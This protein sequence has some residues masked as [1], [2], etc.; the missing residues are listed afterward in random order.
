[1]ASTEYPRPAHKT[2]SIY[3]VLAGSLIG[4]LPMIFH[5]NYLLE[6]FYFNNEWD[7][8]HDMELQGFFNWVFAFR[9]ELFFPVSKFL[10]AGL[11]FAGNGDYHVLIFAVFL[12]HMLILFLLGYLM[13]LWGFGLL[14]T[15]F[16]QCVLGANY[17]HIEI[18]TWTS[19]WIGLIALTSL[20]VIIIPFANAYL[21]DKKLS[22][23]FCVLIFI[24][25]ALGALSFGRGVLNGFVLLGTCLL[26]FVL[27]DSSRKHTWLPA[28]YAVIPC[29]LVAF[30]IAAWS[31][32]RTAN[33]ADSGSQVDAIISWF[34]YSISLN[35]WYQQIRGLQISVGLSVM[36]FALN[37]AVIVVGILL[38]NPKQ[39]PF[40]YLLI[41][42][43]L[44]DAALLALGRNHLPIETVPSWR[45]QYFSILVFAPFVG[46]IL[47][48]IVQFIPLQPVRIIISVVALLLV[49]KWVFDPWA[50]FLPSWS[51]SRGTQTKLL[52][53]SDELD[54]KAH[55]IY[56][57]P[58]ITNDRALELQEKYNL[59]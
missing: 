43:F 34:A 19:Q 33:L 32:S 20:L 18:L 25:S 36:L 35:P 57:F 8:L 2:F 28:I 12:N 49:T 46:I 1:M 13:R 26:L 9:A 24:V 45:Y 11:V 44:G 58:K 50:R 7:M 30:V 59:H 15:L 22:W 53:E 48:R 27:K 54:L 3:W 38:A 42:F 5:A 39:R 6:F 40:L 10:W 51:D 17:T 29:A 31:F 23:K 47:H 37:F 4:W 41:L 55:N 14:A 21:N 52:L 16:V 56:G